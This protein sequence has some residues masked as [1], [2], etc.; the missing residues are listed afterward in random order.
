MRLASFLRAAPRVEGAQIELGVAGNDG[1]FDDL[2][3][4]DAEPAKR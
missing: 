1:Y 3:V 2:K 4:W